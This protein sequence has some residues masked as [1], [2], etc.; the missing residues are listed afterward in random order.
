MIDQMS[1]EA[2]RQWLANHRAVIAAGVNVGQAQRDKAQQFRLEL[3]R[4]HN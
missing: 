2:I 3:V 1:T 4:R